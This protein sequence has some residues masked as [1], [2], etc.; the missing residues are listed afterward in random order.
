[1]KKKIYGAFISI[2]HT[3]SLSHSSV[4]SAFLWVEKEEEEEE[5][6]GAGRGEGAPNF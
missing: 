6:V 5:E 1:M 3:D 4:L 2:L